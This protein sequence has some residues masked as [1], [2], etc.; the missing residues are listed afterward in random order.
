MDARSASIPA[1]YRFPAELQLQIVCDLSYSDL[2]SLRQASRASYQLVAVNEA[3]IVRHHMAH[4]VPP[5]MAKLYRASATADPS[6]RFLAGLAK[7]LDICN[8]LAGLIAEHMTTFWFRR[9]TAAS[10]KKF[11]PQQEVM[12]RRMVPPLFTLLHHFE[13][14][15]DLYITRL[16][17]MTLPADFDP[18]SWEVWERDTLGDYDDQ[19]LEQAHMMYTVLIESLVRQLRPP[20]YAGRLERSLRGWNRHRPPEHQMVKVI[21]VGGIPEV[22]RILRIKNYN[23]RLQ[24]LD[25]WLDDHTRFRFMNGL[26]AHVGQ[27][28]TRVNRPALT[29]EQLL[30]ILRSLPVELRLVWRVAVNEE[31]L[32]RGVVRSMADIPPTP[33]FI[34]DLIRLDD[35]SDGSTVTD[36]SDLSQTDDSVWLPIPVLNWP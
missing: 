4:V 29:P 18:S 24:A 11:A 5:H 22:E 14:F 35:S 23:Q 3:H 10:K 9:T 20:S 17:P 28:P 19:V 33:T 26:L 13:K 31:L 6:L 27:G 1:L 32:A 16:A 7:R 36:A 8:S 25:E 30:L 21:L 2:L 15:R 34:H 12:R